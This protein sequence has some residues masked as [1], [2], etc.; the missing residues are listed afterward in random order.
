[1]GIRT[2]RP[3]FSNLASGCGKWKYQKPAATHVDRSVTGFTRMALGSPKWSTL[4]TSSNES[5]SEACDAR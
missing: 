2:T 3:V 1:M 4:N 5:A